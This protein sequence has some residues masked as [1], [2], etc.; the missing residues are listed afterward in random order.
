MNRR[1]TLIATTAAL[2]LLAIP[3]P[4]AVA[5]EKQ[6][7]SF[8]VPAENTTYPRQQNIEVGDRPNHVVRVFE[9]HNTTSNNAPVI[10]GLKVVEFWSRGITDLTDG[11]GPTTQYSVFTMENGDK[12]FV[13][14]TNVV[15][16]ISG[17]ITATGVGIITGG[18]GKLAAIQ[19][20]ARQDSIID[21]RQGGVPGDTQVDIEYSIGK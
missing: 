20:I 10:N 13:R 9:S 17:K 15:Q 16:N 4:Q 21:P 19:G 6:N 14:F 11:N 2:F 7:F 12:F 8:K 18:T 1:F 5:Q 3:T